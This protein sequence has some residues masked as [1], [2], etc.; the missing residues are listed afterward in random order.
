MLLVEKFFEMFYFVSVSNER[1]ESDSVLG[2]RSG[3]V[4]FFY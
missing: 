3:S 4:G 2:Y 1:F